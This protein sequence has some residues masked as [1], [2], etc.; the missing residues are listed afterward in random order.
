MFQIRW[1]RHI[2]NGCWTFQ[3]RIQG[4]GNWVLPSNPENPGRSCLL[5]FLWFNGA[6]LPCSPLLLIPAAAQLFLPD[7]FVASFKEKS[8]QTPTPLKCAQRDCHRE[9]TRRKLP[10]LSLFSSGSP[11]W[12]HSCH[13]EWSLL[14]W[15]H[16]CPQ[17][18]FMKINGWEDVG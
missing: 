17:A 1:L 5:G 13:H 16:H 15:G 7:F 9:N 18:N 12:K 3:N 11:L 6:G 2:L 8:C 4:D 10:C 14:C